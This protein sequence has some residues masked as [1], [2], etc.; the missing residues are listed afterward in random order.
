[1]NKTTIRSQLLKQRKSLNPNQIASLSEKIV[2]H[3][4]QSEL[5]QQAN[6]IALY[7]PFNGEVDLTA[8]L[9]V[10]HKKH[11]LPSI[12]GKHMQFQRHTPSLLLKKHRYGIDQ[13]EFIGSLQPVQPVQLD[14]CLM[15]LVGFDLNGNRL[16][17]GGGYYDRYFEH[18]V[19][20]N[21][22][23]QLA[24][25]GYQFQQQQQKLPTQ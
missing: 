9:Q 17:M 25:I 22:A 8:L 18:I 13:P 23:T 14:L 15:P 20:D 12:Q 11:Y 24:G 1:M 3:I 5:Y 21:N 19:T 2:K 16:G 10:E 4:T 6:H 7:L